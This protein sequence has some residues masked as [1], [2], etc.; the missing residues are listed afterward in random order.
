MNFPENEPGSGKR[1]NLLRRGYDRV[2][3]RYRLRIRN[4]AI[5]RARTR[6]YLHGRRPEDYEQDILEAI[7]KEEEDRIISEYKSRGIVAL[8]AALGL[9][10]FP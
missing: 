1:P 3:R 2:T 6:I 10:L 7:V 5:E 8:I 9:S 4:K